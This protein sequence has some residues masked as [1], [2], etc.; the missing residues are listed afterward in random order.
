MARLSRRYKR[1]YM[2]ELRRLFDPDLFSDRRDRLPEALDSLHVL[3][4]K[5]AEK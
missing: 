3:H 1:V 5:S 4:E 2:K